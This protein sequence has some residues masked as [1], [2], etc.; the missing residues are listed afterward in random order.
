MYIHALPNGFLF[1]G[2]QSLPASIGD[3]MAFHIPVLSAV[4]ATPGVLSTVTVTV[5]WGLDQPHTAACRGARCN[6]CRI[7]SK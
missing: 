2:E 6:T 3:S 1:P 5:S 7:Q 4:A